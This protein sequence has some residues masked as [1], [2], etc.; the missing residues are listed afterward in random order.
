MG[1]ILGVWLGF[2]LLVAWLVSHWLGIG[3]LLFSWLLAVIVGSYLLRG[4]GAHISQLRQG[5][6][7]L[8]LGGPFARVAAAI[9]FIIPGTL[10]DIAA[11]MLL[12]PATQT[13]IFRRWGRAFSNSK[14]GST[15]GGRIIEGELDQEQG[16]NQLLGPHK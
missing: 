12:I 3:T 11:L 16:K 6:A 9:L 15:Y 1:K 14:P 10:S 5:A 7:G 4:L 8:S 2:E 13:Q